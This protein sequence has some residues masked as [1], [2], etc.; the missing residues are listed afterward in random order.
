MSTSLMSTETIGEKLRRLREENQLPLRKV[1]SMI[2][3]D[4][5]ILSK[6]ERGERRLTKAIV[7]K[8]A[9]IYNYD[10]DELTILYL[11]N[12]VVFEIGEEDLAIKAL[13]VAEKLIRYQKSQM[14]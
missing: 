1:A 11:S 5:A 9:N 2:D 10:I 3:V 6:M 4:V 14:Q 12:K 8:L 13:H 7:Q